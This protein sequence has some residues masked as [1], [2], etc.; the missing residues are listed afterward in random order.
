MAIQNPPTIIAFD[1]IDALS[2]PIDRVPAIMAPLTQWLRGLGDESRSFKKVMLMAATNYPRSIDPGV[3]RRFRT[4][5]YFELTSGD[6]LSKIIEDG[7]KI[8]LKLAQ[9]VAQKLSKEMDRYGLTILGCNAVRACRQVVK[10]KDAGIVLNRLSPEQISDMMAPITG[11]G[12][13]QNQ[14][15]E[16]EK[17][18]AG[19]IDFSVKRQIPYMAAIG[20]KGLVQ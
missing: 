6:V 19:L 16:W 14:V 11:P 7:L 8:D 1:E 18:N 13:F 20:R 17:N 9:K 5:I 3:F 10:D 2:L 15:A 4:A 12:A